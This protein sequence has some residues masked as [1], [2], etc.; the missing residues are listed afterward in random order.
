MDNTKAGT[1]LWDTLYKSTWKQLLI[2]KY[3]HQISAKDFWFIFPTNV[4]KNISF[5]SIEW[6]RG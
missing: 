4:L 3:C 2:H 5:P 1:E 6:L